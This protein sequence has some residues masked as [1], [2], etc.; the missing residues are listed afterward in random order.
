MSCACCVWNAI[1]WAIHFK[2]IWF[3]HLRKIRG[4]C[5]VREMDAAKANTT[6]LEY[7]ACRLPP[8][9]VQLRMFCFGHQDN[10]ICT[11]ILH[12][13]DGILFNQVTKKFKFIGLMY[14]ATMLIRTPGYSNDIGA[15][16]ACI[17]CLFLLRAN[18]SMPNNHNQQPLSSNTLL[19][20]FSGCF[21]AGW[22]DGQFPRLINH[23]IGITWWRLLLFFISSAPSTTKQCVSYSWAFAKIS[24]M[25]SNFLVVKRQSPPPECAQYADAVCC[26]FPDLT[27]LKT[28]LTGPWWDYA[29]ITVYTLDAYHSS[30]C[31]RS[32]GDQFFGVMSCCCCGR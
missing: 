27:P 8:N 17:Y 16:K 14:A 18:Q 28:V 30:S 20:V 29:T 15:E 2:I 12:D 10:I 22:L 19:A 26:L 3:D 25:V 9:A 5:L 13:I 31:D 11:G 32:I 4:V 24:A 1:T 6:V 21:L 23:L 7:E